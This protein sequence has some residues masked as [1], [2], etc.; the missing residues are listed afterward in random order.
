MK[1][2]QKTC[3]LL[4]AGGL[5]LTQTSCND[6][7]DLKPLDAITDV[8]Y[9]Q[10][11]NDFLLAA[12][13][14]YTYERNFGEV[15]YDVVPNSTTV[16]Y[17]AD[18][19]ADLGFTGVANTTNAYSRGLNTVQVT[20]NNY[21]TAYT[22]IRNINYMLGKAAT[23]TSP[24]AIKQYVAEAKFFRAY[25][26]F[27]LLQYYGAVPIVEQTLAPGAPELQLP[28]NSRDEVVNFIIR[29]LTEALP[30]VPAKSGQPTTDLG[31]VNKEV[32]QAFLGRV[33]LYEGTWQK[34]K[35]NAS[36][37]AEMLD[38][39]VTASNA[40]ITSGA[41]SLFAP[42]V[43]GDSAQKYMFILENEKSNP[44]NLTKTA[45]NEY[46]LA[47]RYNSTQRQIRN[48][49]SRQGNNII[50]TRN[51]ANLY[52][53][54][55]GLPV[56]KSP[57]FQGY[58]TIKSEYVNRDN[59]MRYN[60]KM[61]G[62]AYWFGVN[63]PRVDWTGGPADLKT[64]STASF[65]PTINSSTGYANQKWI[66]ERAVADNEEGYDYPVIRYAEVLL[67]YAE[68]I[69]EKN[70]SISDADLD[71]SLN[72][73]RQRVNKSMPKLSNALVNSNGLDMRTEIRRERT[74]ELYMEGFRFDDLKRWNT[75]VSVLSQPLIGVK[76]TGT[77]YQTKWPVKASTPKTANGELI[78]DATRS[79]SEKNYLL[80]I[81]SQQIQLN[82]NLQQTTGW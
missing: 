55:D 30:D 32:V 1:N 73:V 21:N 72:L 2:L 36:R 79:F 34:F 49:I 12:N 3:V 50:P 28:R 63:N 13:A 31:R 53:C 20:D 33:T 39:S 22:R 46:V 80:P 44:A 18:F 62:R 8:S 14:F 26:Y 23:Y 81:P 9:W 38:K 56:E 52:L 61:P 17:H 27:D 43:L 65:D 69:F 5:T 64:A 67:N 51:F 7:L 10:T 6:V 40:V 15:A 74:I 70:G 82:P 58:A 37:G 29:N 59:R 57:L 78:V 42:A 16:N 54:R 77:E 35:G 71:K 24:D 68:A 45:N 25:V 60:L 19:N 76:W 48:N 4:L 11:P 75:A 66:S 47:N 41:Y